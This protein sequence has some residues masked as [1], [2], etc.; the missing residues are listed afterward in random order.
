MSGWR[1]ATRSQTDAIAKVARARGIEPTLPSGA[2]ILL[3][4]LAA[5]GLVLGVYAEFFPRA[6]YEDFPFGRSWVMHDGPYNEHLVR[7]FGAMNLALASV[8][9]AALYFGSRAAARASAIGWLVFSVPHAIYHYR[10][11]SHYDTADKIGTVVSVST[12]IL[13]AVGALVLLSTRPSYSGGGGQSVPQPPPAGLRDDDL[14]R[15]VGAG[16]GDRIDQPG[17]RAS[18]TPTAPTR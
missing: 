11:L 12:G 6:F 16:G 18:L 15:D 7:D 4:L 8:T 3:W 1:P 5:T 13:L 14:R 2:R 9:L 17:A 10:N